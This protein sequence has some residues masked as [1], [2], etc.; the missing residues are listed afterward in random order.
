MCVC[1]LC[2]V[3]VC[4]HVCMYAARTRAHVQDHCDLYDCLESNLP[5]T[6][7]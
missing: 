7:K 3:S 5:L 2:L 4:V 1:R 6:Q